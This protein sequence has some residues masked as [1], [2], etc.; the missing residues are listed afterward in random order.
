MSRKVGDEGTEGVTQM[1]QDPFFQ[2][3][4]FAFLKQNLITEV[5]DFTVAQRPSVVLGSMED[6]VLGDW[7]HVCG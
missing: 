1:K 6:V 4:T 5:N 2:A 7:S 3:L